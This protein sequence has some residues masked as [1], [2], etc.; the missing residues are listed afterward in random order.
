MPVMPDFSRRNFVRL[1]AAV[2]LLSQIAA[3]NVFASAANTV[4]KDPHQK[5]LL[6]PRR[7]DGD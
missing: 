2:P 6:P 1:A 4:G 5:R 3:K 7:K